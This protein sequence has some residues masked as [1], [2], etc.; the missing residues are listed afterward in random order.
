MFVPL[1]AIKTVHQEGQNV[2]FLLV[3][4]FSTSFTVVIDVGLT[5]NW[6]CSSKSFFASQEIT[7]RSRKM[8]FLRGNYAFGATWR[9]RANERRGGTTRTRTRKRSR[10]E[11][12]PI[13]GKRIERPEDFRS[14]LEAQRRSK[15]SSIAAPETNQWTPPL[16]ASKRV[17]S[18][19]EKIWKHVN[20]FQFVVPSDEKR[21]NGKKWKSTRKVSGQVNELLFAFLIFWKLR[22]LRFLISKLC[23]RCSD[24]DWKL[25]ANN[26]KKSASKWD[27]R[28]TFMLLLSHPRIG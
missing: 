5:G 9:S 4:A 19:N 27:S 11:Q 17:K 14:S 3:V 7:I 8:F 20:R 24:R 1:E 16:D 28:I 2:L 6:C 25:R 18:K 12:N 22:L 15:R 21:G 13:E 10:E 23:W 26:T